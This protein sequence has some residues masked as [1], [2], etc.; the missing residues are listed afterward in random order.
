L[1]AAGG[2]ECILLVDREV[3]ALFRFR[4]EPRRESRSFI[5]HLTPHHQARKIMLVSGDR[6]SEVRYLAQEIGIPEVHFGKSPE[7]VAIVGVKRG[8]LRRCSSATGSAR[9]SCN[10]GGDCRRGCGRASD[11]TAEAAAA[12]ILENSLEKV[13]ELIYIGRRMR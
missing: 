8:R 10:A 9:R 12:V 1:P 4:D 5:R 13:D 3:A 7:K 11:I 6:E 2:L